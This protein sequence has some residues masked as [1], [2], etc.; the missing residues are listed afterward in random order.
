MNGKCI[1]C[2]SKL[3]EL[4]VYVLKNMPEKVQNLP[5]FNELDADKGIDLGLYQCTGC[6]LLQLDCEPVNYYKDSTRA[7]EKSAALVNLRKQQYKDFIERYNLNGK[8]IIEIGAGKGGFL[9]TLKDME[10]YDIK[11]FG[12][13]N[14]AE[15]VKFAREREHVN[16]FQGYIDKCDINLEGAPYDAFTC[17]SYPAR[18]IDPNTMLQGIRHNLVSNGVGI[19]MCLSQEYILKED[20][21]FEVTRDLYAYYSQETLSFLVRKNG[22]DVLEI[23]NIF[24]Y[25]YAVVKKRSPINLKEIWSNAEQIKREVLKFAKNETKDGKK[26]G[27]WCAGHY[28]FTVLSMSG[29]GS[30]ISYIIDN[31][32]FKQ[33]H[34]A[35]VSHVPI[36]GSNYFRTEPVECILILGI[37]YVDEIIQEIRE[38]CSPVVKIAV[39][40][41][42]GIRIISDKE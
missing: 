10:E 30:Y 32:P 39:M 38:K 42:K 20:G 31:A 22:F 16:V 8:K 2:N 26:L 5:V 25:V 11:E 21:F 13:E 7:G 33:G 40:D 35:P 28:S 1:V 9:R 12:I 37:F 23:G 3:Y 41:N 15:Y 24:P 19:I 29:A 17:F 4:P 14:N 36:V 34:Y 6:G 27:V 18:M